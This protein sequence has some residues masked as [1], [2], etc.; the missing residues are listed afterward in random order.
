MK[1]ILCYGDS[2][3]RGSNPGGGRWEYDKRWPG[4]L[5]SLLGDG[6]Y[7]IEEGLGGRTTVFDDPFERGRNGKTYLPVVLASHQPIDL[8]IISLGTN[9]TKRFFGSNERIITR[10]IE[11]LADVAKT[12]DVKQI[13]VISPIHVGERIEETI[14]AGFSRESVEISYKLS[15]RVKAMAER[16][17]LIFFDAATVATPSEIDQLHMDAESHRS[18]AE[19]LKEVII[20]HL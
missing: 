15:E 6:Y 11:A 17:D 5:S 16:K 1:T 13:M 19:A 4:I 20:Q 9:D 12:F 2:N 3:T 18:L 8:L 10:G 7:V 14:F